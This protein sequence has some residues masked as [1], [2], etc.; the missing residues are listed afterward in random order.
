MRCPN[1][2][3]KMRDGALYCEQ[4]GEDI[5]IVP[6]F[7]P[8]LD[9]DIQQT[10]KSIADDILE[11]VE[12]REED[13]EGNPP[14]GG[15]KNSRKWIAGAAFLVLFL[16]V[17]GIGGAFLYL[18]RSAEYQTQKA[19]ECVEKG[20]YDKAAVYYERAIDLKESNVDLKAEL[21]EV[22]YLKNNKVE[23]EHLLREITA[24]KN[25]TQE[26]LESAYGKLVAIYR[27]RGDYQT[28]NDFLLAS[29][30]E[31][32]IAAYQG[33]VAAAPEFSVKAGYYNSIQPLKL[34][35]SGNGH[36]Y[37]TMDGTDPTEDS[38][39]YTTPIL[40]EK[41]DYLI[42][43]FFVNENGIVSDIAVAEYH[44]VIEKLPEP[45]ISVN[46]GEYEIPMDIEITDAIGD[47]YYTTDGTDPSVTST[48][49]T[50]PI[51]MPLGESVF[52]FI[53]IEE[54]G[55]TSDVVER[56]FQLT[57]D[58]KVSTADAERIVLDDRINAGRIWD[59]EGNF[60]AENGDR[61]RYQYQFVDDIDGAGYYYVIAE[62]LQSADG[63]SNRTGSYY[64]VD[65]YSGRLFRLQ[66]DNDN[67][68]LVEIE[69]SQE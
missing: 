53:C 6:D 52:R 36:I 38:E 50:G 19:R 56:T 4:C 47:V 31:K 5:H 69:E 10:I 60:G 43:A 40:L 2:G 16:I 15:G 49:Y 21:A 25:A 35:T 62:I 23:Y 66:N 17:G 33:Y 51:H 39:L 26:Q 34:T 22:Y 41:G 12:P 20:L 57:L 9:D 8:E 59:A 32:V 65:V 37:Y 14:Q 1:C 61:Y 28:I 45:T 63:T 29:G 18:Y 3:A 24:D 44:I 48:P 30:N 13:A 67:Y 58:T 68:V 46:S 7:E 54:D 27:N 55:R 64:A 42:K 11:Q